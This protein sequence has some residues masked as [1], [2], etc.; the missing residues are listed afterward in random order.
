MLTKA[1]TYHSKR[2]ALLA[3]VKST[4]LKQALGHPNWLKAMQIEHKTLLANHTWS[5]TSLPPHRELVVCKWVF[6]IKENPNGTVNK[7]KSRLVA[8][9]RKFGFDFNEN[10]TPVV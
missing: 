9:G 5:L 3:H 8:K 7:Y 1:K 6:K 4:S 2:K 10:I